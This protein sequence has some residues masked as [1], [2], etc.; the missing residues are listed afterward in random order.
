[1]ARLY[2]NTCFSAFGTKEGESDQKDGP[3]QHRHVKHGGQL[4]CRLGEYRVQAATQGVVRH[5]H[6]NLMLSCCCV[7]TLLANF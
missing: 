1:M 2:R 7:L 3:L 5:A 6:E 4:D